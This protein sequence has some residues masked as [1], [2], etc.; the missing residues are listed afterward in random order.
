MPEGL[1]RG[2]K[3]VAKGSAKWATL[4]AHFWPF[5][6]GTW[7]GGAQEEGDAVQTCPRLRRPALFTQLIDSKT[8]EPR[9]VTDSDQQ[10]RRPCRLIQGLCIPR[11]GSLPIDRAL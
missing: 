8:I 9:E 7:P 5:L 11:N 2:G 3:G 4:G 1:P 6:S 10:T